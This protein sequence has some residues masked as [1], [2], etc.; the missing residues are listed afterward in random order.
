MTG[1]FSIAEAVQSSNNKKV[2]TVFT[3]LQNGFSEG[4]LKSLEAVTNLVGTN[5]AATFSNL[6]ETI[7]F[8][9]DYK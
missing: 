9:N 4:Q 6:D 2:L 5:G 3:V 8:L 7:D 1:V